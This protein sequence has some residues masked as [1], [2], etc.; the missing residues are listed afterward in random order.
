MY[1]SQ[2]LQGKKRKLTQKNFKDR[3]PD[4]FLACNIVDT[5]Y[6]GRVVKEYVK[7]CLSF[8]PLPDGKKEH[9]RIIAGSMTSTMRSF[10]GI[11]EKNRDHHLHHAQDAIII[12]CI[13]P[14]MIQKYTTYLKEKE[15]HYLKSHQKAQILEE[16]D[17]K[18]K[19]ALR[20][21]MLDFKDKVQE[22]IKK[23]IVSHS[24]SYKVTGALHE[25]TVRKREFYY[26]SFGGEEGVKKAL[27]LGKI[28]EINQGIV[29]NG[30][31]VR[32][33]IFKSRDKGKFYAVPI[34]T[35]DFAVGKLPNKA[36][37]V[38]KQSDGVIKD[39]LEMDGNYEFCFS[40][41]KNDYIK[42][43]STKMQNPVFV[44]Y[45]RTHSGM[46]SITFEHLS[47]YTCT[48]DERRLFRLKDNELPIQ[49]TQGIQ[50]LKLLQKVKLSP[51]GEVLECKPRNRQ[52]IA[53]KNSK[54]NNFERL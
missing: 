51:L 39:W 21:P 11:Q 19:L 37:V 28:R 36:I 9:I 3:S 7:S 29:D 20:W 43:Q 12:G 31:M 54:K 24:V 35:Y 49:G 48:K 32:V 47:R 10:W 18:T 17:Y 41:F 25:E 23:I 2:F 8:L 1:K 13:Q 14:S 30:A 40:L 52:N 22:S 50:G 34:Y 53:L 4:E 45:K 15:T 44:I 27:E 33:D 5:S 16:G 6:I 42:I 26:K 46:A 38:G